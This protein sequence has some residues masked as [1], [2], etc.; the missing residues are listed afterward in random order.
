VRRT[1]VPLLLALAVAGGVVTWLLQ[2]ALVASGQATLVP[3]GTLVLVLFGI[4]AVL[5]SLGWP[6]RQFVRGKRDR[7]IDPFQATRTLLFAKASSLMG[8]LL[9]GAAVGILLYLFSRPV[10]AGGPSV[11]LTVGAL[12]GAVAV[13]ASGL[14][15]EQWCRLPP[16]DPER[17][18]DKEAR[19]P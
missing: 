18:E 2:I 3:P 16:Q 17:D 11:L 5:L 10:P 9:A 4:A 7:R 6:I 15:V 1:S 8:S 14:V 19:H 13:A 12:V